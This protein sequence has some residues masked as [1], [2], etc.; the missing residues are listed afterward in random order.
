MQNVDGR[1]YSSS[2]GSYGTIDVNAGGYAEDTSVDGG[3]FFVSSGGTAEGT[4]IASGHEYI[5][6]TD[7]NAKVF[8]GIQEIRDFGCAA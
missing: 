7:N 3:S 2:V 5:S 6:G 4:V 1:A 8:G